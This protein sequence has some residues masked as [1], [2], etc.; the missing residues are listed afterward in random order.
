[1]NIRIRITR[2]VAVEV[3][4]GMVVTGTIGV[5][6]S[7]ATEVGAVVQVLMFV[8]HVIGADMMNAVV[9]AGH[10][11]GIKYRFPFP[12]YSVVNYSALP[13]CY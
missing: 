13:L 5:K 11:E 12:P 7:I 6:E 2:E 4:R 8:S 9:G 10:M 3:G 1:M